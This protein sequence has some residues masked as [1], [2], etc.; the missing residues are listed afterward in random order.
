MGLFDFLGQTALN[1]AKSFETI[2]QHPIQSIGTIGNQQKF[3]ALSEKTNNAPLLNQVGQVLLTTGTAAATV[4]GGGAALG[5]TTA[6]GIVSAVAPV[7]AKIGTTIAKSPI[8]STAAIGVG[9]I[10]VN[11]AK[12]SPKV[13]T[14]ILNTPS[15][16]ANFGSNI[17][18]AVE[19]P[20][21]TSITNIAKQNPLLTAGTVLAAGIAAGT[22]L[23]TVA[24][25]LNTRATNQN[26][27]STVNTATM[28]TA[29][30][31]AQ[32]A[33]INYLVT[34]PM[35]VAAT[36]QPAPIPKTTAV[37]KK[38]SKKKKKKTIKRRKTTKKHGKSKV[39]RKKR[40]SKH[41]SKRK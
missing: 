28:P 24:T 40:T 25:V 1:A 26:S 6:R 10:G 5:S 33:P 34:Q 13:A 29:P 30:V 27:N 35:P 17:G 38:K 9:I 8:K 18:K 12:S 7:I 19:N 31:Q 39:K 32:P 14:A 23:N 11:A 16:L 36:P 22:T 2:V 41:T 20:N 21:L 37:G 15:S 3:N 4:I